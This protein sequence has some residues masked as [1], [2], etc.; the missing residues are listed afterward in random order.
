L[1]RGR[2]SAWLTSLSPTDRKGDCQVAVTRGVA[3][4]V[5]K[6]NTDWVAIFVDA[7]CRGIFISIVSLK[8]KNLRLIRR[9]KDFGHDER[10]IIDRSNGPL[11]EFRLVS[12]R[13]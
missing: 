6:D 12:R 7:K 3:D 5:D 9:A 11:V 4:E 13:S 2:C 1:D 8:V 10:R